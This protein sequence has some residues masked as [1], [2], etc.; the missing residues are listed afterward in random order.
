MRQLCSGNFRI[1]ICFLIST[2]VIHFLPTIY[3]IIW[4]LRF[5]LKIFGSK[6]RILHFD[7]YFSPSHSDS[8]G[9]IL[10]SG[11]FFRFNFGF[12]SIFDLILMEFFLIFNLYFFQIELFDWATELLTLLT[13]FSLISHLLQ[14][15][16]GYS[17]LP[18][19]LQYLNI[20]CL[21]YTSDAA[22]E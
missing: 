21:L 9:S 22:D 12:F 10:E 20:A 8:N 6:I 16:I 7:C 14:I 15:S 2:F 17:Q 11:I 4:I 1:S 19:L 5:E 13:L 3:P 18:L